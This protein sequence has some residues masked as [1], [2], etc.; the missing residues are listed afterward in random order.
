MFVPR[1]ARQWRRERQAESRDIEI[2]LYRGT[3]VVGWDGD[4]A[5]ERNPDFCS[6][7]ILEWDLET[8]MATNLMNLVK[9]PEKS[10]D[11]QSGA[12][13]DWSP[14]GDIFVK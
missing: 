4:C 6:S 13:V 11:I 3:H 1:Y 7:T 10:A 14:L 8:E 12:T 9:F 5:T 2:Y